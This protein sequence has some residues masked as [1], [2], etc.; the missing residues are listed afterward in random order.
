VLK[1][2]I[3]AE[4][5][6]NWDNYQRLK[7]MM[8]RCVDLGITL[9]K[10]QLWRELQV[11]DEVRHMHINEELARGI[12]EA[13][14]NRNLEVIFT[15][16]YPEAVDICE[17]IGVNYYKIRYNDYYTYDR[18][19]MNKVRDTAKPYFLSCMTPFPDPAAI[20]L[21]CVPD[22][23]AD[24]GKYQLLHPDFMGISDH[25]PDLRLYK[26]ALGHPNLKYFEMHVC[27]DKNCYE[28]T[29][30]KTFEAIEEVLL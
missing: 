7:K 23:P 12:F 4:F 9:V 25:T 2:E 16:F 29:W 22:Y 19:V 11:P 17:R 3:I 1:I 14:L 20:N 24:P 5:G 26:K 28:Y 27:M 30:S 8:D 18:S 21:E 13:G 6:C 10:F 15:P